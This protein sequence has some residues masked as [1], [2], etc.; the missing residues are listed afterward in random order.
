MADGETVAPT[1][2]V[3][4]APGA[5]AEAGSP[6]ANV[7]SDAP[8]PALVD[9]SGVTLDSGAQHDAAEA[10]KVEKG[11]D[12]W[13]DEEKAFRMRFLELS[14]EGDKQLA[15]AN[16]TALRTVATEK[17]LW[18]RDRKEL[19]LALGHLDKAKAAFAELYSYLDS[20]GRI[21]QVLDDR[22]VYKK[23]APQEAMEARLVI[24]KSLCVARE[25]ADQ[26][27]LKA[28]D[29]IV[30]VS[31][32][33]GLWNSW[34]PPIPASEFVGKLAEARRLCNA[35]RGEYK[36]IASLEKELPS[37]LGDMNNGRRI[38]GKNTLDT[39]V[40][41]QLEHEEQ[42]AIHRL[43]GDQYLD[44]VD[45]ALRSQLDPLL[46]S[47]YCQKLFTTIDEDGSG[48][49]DSQEL[50]VALTQLK[51]FLTDE[52]VAAI[53]TELD[54]DRNGTIDRAEW[55]R[56]IVLQKYKIY[57][58][59]SIANRHLKDATEEYK[60][61]GAPD[62]NALLVQYKQRIDKMTPV[63]VRERMLGAL[64]GIL[65]GD[66]LG[67]PTDGSINCRAISRDYGLVNKFMDPIRATHADGGMHLGISAHLAHIGTEASNLYPAAV[68]EPTRKS[69]IMFGCDR[70]HF[71][72]GVHPHRNL[73]GGRTT[74]TGEMAK[75]VA[76]SLVDKQR[77]DK[78]HFLAEYIKYMLE[79]SDKDIFV[80][81]YHIEYFDRYALGNKPYYS[82]GQGKGAS[83]HTS[84]A[85]VQIT[86]LVTYLSM[87]EELRDRTLCLLVSFTVCLLVSFM[88]P[89]LSSCLL[90]SAPASCNLKFLSVSSP[91]CVSVPLVLHPL[92]LAWLFSC[93]FGNIPC[94][95]L[96]S[97][98]LW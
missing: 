20:K 88:S 80:D 32:M 93:I 28:Q 68:L 51:V 8:T 89:L 47:E 50:R 86:P 53:V 97:C 13:S 35:A 46:T 56:G 92:C 44:D 31:T 81:K 40:F 10:P 34:E 11:R 49:I 45:N 94:V 96:C 69:D 74:M 2:A 7:A 30:E 38:M 78:D 54:V 73:G 26:A 62:R 16:T 39:V 15:F 83:E 63:S 82:A 24:L 65:S 1:L 66:A 33:A 41:P 12:D 77:F 29:I 42:K 71:Q 19:R 18:L 23:K 55:E 25:E 36:Y 61:A 37:E 43:C 98:I 17:R 84:R 22:G 72:R 95:A 85:L 60:I 52:E 27:A 79:T 87:Q 90:F 4:P 9:A 59:L 3:E 14:S 70:F 75:L 21:A 58:L 64:W 48:A 5:A 76:K 91:L 6:L 67:V 57:L